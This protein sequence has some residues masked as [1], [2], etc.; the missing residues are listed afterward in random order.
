MSL[1]SRVLRA[2][3]TTGVV[4]GLVVG[5]A[6]CGGSDGVA[7]LDSSSK[8]F[9]EPGLGSAPKIDG[10]PLPAGEF[11][12]LTGTTKGDT[13]AFSSLSGAPAIVN[14]WSTTCGP[15]VKEMPA[16]QAVHQALGD[17][18]RIV[19]LNTGDTPDSA[20]SFVQKVA[21]TYPIWLDDKGDGVAALKITSLPTTIFVNAEGTIVRTKVGAMDAA[22]MTA[23]VKELFGL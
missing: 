8:T 9:T 1:V 19:G 15:C 11:A 2:A 12:V 4:A 22:A 6:A 10:K 7:K 13:V 3:A 5:V 21:V 16:F 14:V 17:K 18:V 20:G 23:A